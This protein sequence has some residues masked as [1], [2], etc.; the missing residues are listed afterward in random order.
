MPVAFDQPGPDATLSEVLAEQS[1]DHLR[2]LLGLL[3]RE[4]PRPT[5]KAE[6]AAAIGRRLDGDLLNKLWSRLNRNQRHA[7]SEVLYGADGVFHPSRFQAKYGALPAGIPTAHGYETRT[8]LLN[9]FLFAGSSYGDGTA[10]IPADLRT[11][12]ARSYHPHRR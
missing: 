6:M 10:I 11:D 8:T 12:C 9:L 2:S 1:A 7:V 4:R 5:R 3:P